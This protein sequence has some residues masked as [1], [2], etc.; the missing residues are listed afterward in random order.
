MTTVEAPEIP[1]YEARSAPRI[2]IGAR[3]LTI[4]AQKTTTTLISVRAAP[5]EDAIFAVP[6]GYK[7]QPAP[8]FQ[9]QPPK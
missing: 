6:E 2:G 4:G 3:E 8:L 7:E 5:L 9:F 1:T